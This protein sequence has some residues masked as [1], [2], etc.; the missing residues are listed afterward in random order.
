MGVTAHTNAWGSSQKVEPRSNLLITT[1]LSTGAV[2]TSTSSTTHLVGYHYRVGQTKNAY[3]PVKGTYPNT[4]YRRVIARGYPFPGQYTQTV[5]GF[6]HVRSGHSL[7]THEAYGNLLSY[8][9]GNGFETT[10]QEEVN[11]ATTEALVK[12]NEGKVNIATYMAEAIK[13]ADTIA[14][15]VIPFWRDLLAI[16]RGKIPRNLY[17]RYNLNRV[18]QGYLEWKYGWRPLALDLYSIYEDF[19][20][21]D[22][23]KM[24]IGAVSSATVQYGSTADTTFWTNR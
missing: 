9:I 15:A 4:S 20:T 3:N 1:N 19:R 8:P 12:L 10:S 17:A 23:M 14:G 7:G 13:S 24:V 21:V 16:K 11:R 5:S 6:R 2:T 18:P 22:P